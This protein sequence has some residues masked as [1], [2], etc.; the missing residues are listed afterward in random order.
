[1]SLET[2]WLVVPVVGIGLT[3]PVWTWLWL[4]RPKRKASNTRQV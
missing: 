2:Y 1:M 4:T 3:L